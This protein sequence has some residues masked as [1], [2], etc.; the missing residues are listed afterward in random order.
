MKIVKIQGGLGNQMFQ[1]AFAK[2]LE[3]NG[4]DVFLDTS[5]Y[6]S[7][8]S[9]G[10]INYT[11]NGFELEDLFNIQY[12]KARIE[13]VK[14]LA[15]L[16]TNFFTRIKRKYFTKKTHYIDRVFKY[17]PELFDCSKDCYLEGYWQTEKYFLSI[18]DNIR[19][20][21]MFTNQASKQT[22]ELISQID[23]KD[24]IAS[25][26]VRRG[27]YLNGKSHAVCTETYFNNA[28]KHLLQSKKI[29]RFL[30]FSNDMQWAKEMLDFQNVPTTFVDWNTGIDSWQDMYIMGKCPVNIISNSSFSWWAAWL[31][32]HPEKVVITPNIWS[33]SELDYKDSYYTFDYS[34]I[35]PSN[36][37]RIST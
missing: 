19:K 25:I 1:Y 2:A 36:W 32:K 20:T 24:C 14:K 4:H 7:S 35:V 15:T 6:N 17:S 16:P 23:G 33:R 10:G 22:Q 13:D 21:F 28:I 9:R 8:V 11:H 5:L 26:H 37:E 29:E 27:D 12:K 31:N 30:V 34:D 18:E 3:H